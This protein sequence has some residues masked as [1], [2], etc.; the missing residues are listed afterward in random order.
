MKDLSISLS[1]R[2]LS[3]IAI[4]LLLVLALLAAALPATVLA[5]TGT[6]ARY[7]TVQSG[8]TLSSVSVTYDISILELA[9]AN[10]LKEP[11]PIFVGQQ[12]CIPG[13]APSTTTTTST[14][15]TASQGISA[16]F[17]DNLVAIKLTDVKKKSNYIIKAR[18]YH[19]AND[20]WFKFARVN[21]DK[22]GNATATLKLPRALWDGEYL[23]VCAKNSFTDK[24]ECQR[25]YR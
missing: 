24:V 9:A 4:S 12:L 8:D 19:R 22:N 5:Q 11:Y 20:E 6:C 17:T 18:K 25:F 21:T 13:V 15:T 16:T 23:E 3:L 7:Y 2:R 1:P 14:T 10:N